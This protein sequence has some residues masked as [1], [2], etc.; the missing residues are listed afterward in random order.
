MNPNVAEFNAPFLLASE[1]AGR[2]AESLALPRLLAGQQRGGVSRRKRVVAL[3]DEL[4]PPLFGYL[5]AIGVS[6][7]QAEDVIQETF[8]RLFRD[9]T[10]ELVLN[11]VRPWAFRVAQNVAADEHRKTKRLISLSGDV[12]RLID[13]KA[14]PALN[15]EESLAQK[16]QLDQLNA[17]V[18]KLPSQQRQC[19]HL[20]AAGLRYREI[21]A[22]LGVSIPRVTVLMERALAR[23]IGD[24]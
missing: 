5:C 6:P 9:F 14:D 8:L 15:P 11:N 20:R 13:L 3:Y 23:L 1:D 7:E 12:E 21:A 10:A 16:E 17:A 2:G 18:A 24:L 4:R 19:L 22:A